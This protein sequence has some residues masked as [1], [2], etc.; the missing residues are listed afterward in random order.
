MALASP[1]IEIKEIELTRSIDVSDQTI[2][3]VPLP[4]V[5]GP[6]DKV[7]FINSRKELIDIFGKPNNSNFEYWFSA[8]TIIQYGGILATYRPS[9]DQLNNAT[10]T[11]VS[12][13]IKNY[14]DYYE[15]KP[16]LTGFAIAS[17]NPSD[18]YNG[19]L[20]STVSAKKLAD[21]NALNTISFTIDTLPAA[22]TLDKEV[23]L[24]DVS[25][26]V[27]LGVGTVVAIRTNTANYTVYVGFVG[28]APTLEVGDE[29]QD[30]ANANAVLETASSVSTVVSTD[31]NWDVWNV[32]EYKPGKLWTSLFVP[33]PGTSEYGTSR[34]IPNDE[35]HVIVV[36]ETG[37]LSGVAGTVVER[38]LGYSSESAATAI[39]GSSLYYQNVIEILSSYI[40]FM[41]DIKEAPPKQYILN[42]G[43]NYNF[44]VGTEL[45]KVES[46]V[47]GS[48]DIIN[49][50]ESYD[51]IDFIVPG[52]I[53]A[54]IAA[55]AI[56]VATERKDCIACISP[57]RSDVIG[58]SLSPA[59]KN[60]N[61]INFFG[62]FSNS[63]YAVFDCNYKYIYDEFNQ[64]YRYIP[65]AADVA[66]LMITTNNN[67]EPW[68]SPAGASRGNIRN[69]VQLA[70]NPNK[71]QRDALYINRIN[72]IVVV[73]GS[74]ARLMGDKT[75]L[76]FS[77]VFDR[78]NV[79]RLFIV[80]EK[81]VGRF[82]RDQLFEINDET[83]RANFRT[84]VESYMRSVEARRGVES[85]RVVCD[86]TNNTPEVINRNEFVADIFI[87]P[88]RSINFIQLNFIASATDVTFNE[89]I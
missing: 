87:R 64:V 72:P 62:Q 44:T 57:E 85:F 5:K 68:F 21:Y 73:P 89:I 86:T 60:L 13:L 55:E 12:I 66:G 51:D 88:S 61:V 33:K 23:E 38:Y 9:T 54:S 30:P 48:F 40:Y 22:L 41:E 47:Q 32:T 45:D 10:D 50:P 80:L 75:A 17:R 56:T 3:F 29:I 27:S 76:S 52:K 19:L 35:V 46:A 58:T 7:T 39:D 63:S 15:N 79:R 16:T 53:T 59:Q 65:C 71:A 77:S 20:V 82:A 1:G 36:D 34:N 14:E 78:I 67:S 84:T 4:A 26:T 8:A 37:L 83:T 49:D 11:G 69:A 43:S 6:L 18:E 31:P 70:Y 81:F 25:G 24:Y 42:G 2:A 28:A 74:G